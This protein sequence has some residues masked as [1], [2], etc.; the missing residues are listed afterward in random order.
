[1]N[2]RL[3]ALP[4]II[5]AKDPMA[6]ALLASGLAH[7]LVVVA[8]WFA[9]RFWSSAPATSP[10][11][12]DVS[13]VDVTELETVVPAAKVGLSDDARA[14]ADLSRAEMI[15]EGKLEHDQPKPK[16]QPAKAR[17][18]R[19][20]EQPQSHPAVEMP[21]RGDA[22]VGG[23]SEAIE[24][25]RV[26]YRDLIAAKLARS[27][28]YPERAARNEVTGRGVLQLTLDSSGGVRDVSVTESTQARILDDEMLKM[29]ERAAPFPP[30]P[31]EMQQQQISLVV[32]V[33]FRLER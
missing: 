15:S 26:N 22:L 25:A 9:P 30:F 6:G 13:V 33:S 11:I 8:L 28:R 1:M 16:P 32:P 20:V 29:V 14:S 7:L 23:G 17:E 31:A 21:A 10:L 19:K 3:K 18:S 5:G 2:S 27:K 4:S 12:I 24:R